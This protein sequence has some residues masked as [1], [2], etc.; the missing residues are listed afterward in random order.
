M[1]AKKVVVRTYALYKFEN[2]VKD[3]C[4]LYWDL[5]DEERECLSNGFEGAESRAAALLLQLDEANSEAAEVEALGT[6]I[7]NNE[8]LPSEVRLCQDTEGRP[9][10][11][12]GKVS[13]SAQK[14]GDGWYSTIGGIVS[15]KF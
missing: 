4:K 12:I 15:A 13:F 10:L 7:E 5:Y 8:V 11:G 6:I 14:E 1:A 2:F 3:R 9:L